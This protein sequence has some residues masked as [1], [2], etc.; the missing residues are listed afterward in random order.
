MSFASQPVE[1]L[2]APS[3]ECVSIVIADDSVE[4]ETEDFEVVIDSPQFDNAVSLGAIDRAT[5][6]IT[7]DG[8]ES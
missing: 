7:N 1:F 2:T 8:G 3:Q 4:E 6:F 5:V